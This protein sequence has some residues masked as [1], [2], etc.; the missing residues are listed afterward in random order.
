MRLQ[1]CF[2]RL[3]ETSRQNFAAVNFQCL[4]FLTAHQVD[5]ELGDSEAGKLLK[6][7]A[8]R[9]GRAHEAKTIYNFIGDE[10]R[11]AAVDFA[12]LLVIVST[13]VADKRSES[14]R[15]FIRLITREQVDDVIGNQG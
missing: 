15:E 14:G 1:T 9:F 6:F 4:L 8:M 12:M 2:C 3:A 7:L 13:T 10:L 11:V 5:V